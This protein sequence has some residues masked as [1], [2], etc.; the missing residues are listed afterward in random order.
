MSASS[1]WT[2]ASA[3]DQGVRLPSWTPGQRVHALLAQPNCDQCP[4]KYCRKVLP[5]GPI[6]ARIAFVAENPGR[7]E[8][9]DGYGLVGPTGQLVWQMC[10]SFGLTRDQ[11]WVSNSALCRPRDITLSNGAVIPEQQ[12][13]VMSAWACRQRLLRELLMVGPQVV[14]PIGNFA[15][16]AVSDLPDASIFAYRGSR[17]DLDLEAVLTRVV[18][19]KEHAP[20]MRARSS[21]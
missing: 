12:V 9:Q 14:V 3:A 20:I 15:L 4:L 7:Q 18:A 5:D 2:Q 8:E 1:L 10:A 11:V 21:K 16:W 17:L 13:K 6:P 19:G